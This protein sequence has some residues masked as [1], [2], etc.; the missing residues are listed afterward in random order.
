MKKLSLLLSLFVLCVVQAQDKEYTHSL[1]GVKKVQVTSNASIKVLASATKNLMMT[2]IKDPKCEECKEDHNHHNVGW[3]VRGERSERKQ[4]KKDK[5]AGLTPIYPGGKDDTNGFGFSITKE[6]NT[7][8]IED[9]KSHLQSNNIQLEIPKNLDLSVDSGN[10]GSI[11]IKGFS[12]EVE[13]ESNVGAIHMTDVT[14]PITAHSSTGPINIDFIKVNQSSPITVSSSVGEI[15]VSLPSNTDANL[16]INTNGTVY[17]N[18]DLKQKAK[19]DLPQVSGNRKITS[20]INKGGVKIK[21]KSSL[22]NI[23]LRKK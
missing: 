9:L 23:Y 11:T 8:I 1:K 20:P 21:L 18:F 5:R 13:A 16:D 15:D 6:G 3:S 17:T 22:G 4:K 10:L 19:K 14:G 2:C 7:L 12:S